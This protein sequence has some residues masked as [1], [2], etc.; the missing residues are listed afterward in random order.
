MPVNCTEQGRWRYEREFV[1]SDYMAN[2]KT[3]RAKLNSRYINENRQSAVW[4]SIDC[5]EERRGFASATHAMSESYDNIRE[6]LDVREFTI[7]DGQNGVLVIVDGEIK[8]FELFLN[9]EIYSDYHEKILKSYLIDAEINDNVYEISNEEAKKYIA[10]AVD[11]E[12]NQVP[13]TGLET[14]YE[15][16]NSNGIGTVYTYEDEI[17][18]LSYFSNEDDDEIIHRPYFRNEYDDENLSDIEWDEISTYPQRPR[19]Y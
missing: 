5:L 8:G 12:F 7:A 14:S 2:S 4:R 3:R 16:R 9:S 10:N 6:E 19:R 11:G 13:H 18:H 15:F 17:I 1:N